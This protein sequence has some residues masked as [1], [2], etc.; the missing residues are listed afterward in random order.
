[1][2]FKDTHKPKKMIHELT[3][4]YGFDYPE[5]L[6]IRAT[7]SEFVKTAQAL[8]SEGGEDGSCGGSVPSF[9]GDADSFEDM[10]KRCYDGYSAKAIS[11]KRYEI[12]AMLDYHS[13]SA[14]L[15]HCGDELDVPTYLSG[16]MRCWWADADNVNT[17]KRIHIVY[18]ANCVADVNAESFIN[19]GGAVASICDALDSM[20]ALTKITC[21]FTNTAVFN[22]RGL[23][24]IEIKDYSESID[25][26][27]IGATTHP[28]F[29]RRIGFKYFEQ[30]CNSIGVNSEYTYGR[31]KTGK[32]RGEAVSDK[33][34]ADWL[35]ISDDEIVVDLAAA[36]LR[37]FNDTKTTAEWVAYAISKIEG[38]ND[39]HIKIF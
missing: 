32:E 27:R 14:E 39:R 36:D 37:V 9:Y 7:F 13:E 18:G 12:G 29:F 6:K 19:H 1:M 8:P 5:L 20:G 16:D 35:R 34:F 3:T 30:F 26:P 33:E 10:V 11:E 4:D 28:S 23:Q 2:S 31:S 38:S 25:I 17:P 15:K 24:A 21:T 22:G